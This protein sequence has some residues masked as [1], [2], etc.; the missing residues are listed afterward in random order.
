M[1]SKIEYENVRSYQQLNDYKAMIP[2]ERTEPGLESERCRG[3][4]VSFSSD[5]DGSSGD[6]SSSS[7]VGVTPKGLLSLSVSCQQAEM[8]IDIIELGRDNERCLGS[9]PTVS[10]VSSGTAMRLGPSSSVSGN[11]LD[12]R[13]GGG[14]SD[15]IPAFSSHGGENRLRFGD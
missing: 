7:S 15:V 2:K 12:P 3:S 11:C 13:R 5:G 1:E 6:S 14:D 4:I 10:S 9:P 8:F